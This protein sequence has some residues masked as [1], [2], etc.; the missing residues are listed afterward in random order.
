MFTLV[1]PSAKYRSF[2]IAKSYC[3]DKLL[4]DHFEDDLHSFKHQPKHR[5]YSQISSKEFDNSHTLYAFA[6]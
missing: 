6:T 5:K 2:L 4:T 3:S 1:Y